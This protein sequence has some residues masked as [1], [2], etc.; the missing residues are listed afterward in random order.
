MKIL[1][2]L[3]IVTIFL[4]TNIS[5]VFSDITTSVPTN[6]I[7]SIATATSF[8]AIN[9]NT[10]ESAGQVQNITNEAINTEQVLEAVQEGAET[11]GQQNDDVALA[12]F[13]N[14]AETVTVNSEN[15]NKFAG[16]SDL[17]PNIDTL[18]Y[19]TGMMILKKKG[20]HYNADNPTDPDDKIFSTAFGAQRAR[21]LVYVDLKRN[22]LLGEIE[23]QVT[24]HIGTSIFTTAKGASNDL[25][26]IEF[27]LDGELTRTLVTSTGKIGVGA[28]DPFAWY[29]KGV[30]SKDGK[31]S[32]T[33]LVRADGD[34]AAFQ[35]NASS[36]ENEDERLDLQ[37]ALSHASGGNG[38]VHIGAR[39]VTPGEGSMGTSTAS[40]EASHAAHNADADVFAAGVVRYSATETPSATN[41]TD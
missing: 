7:Q 35:F 38:N 19:D 16:R 39:F 18:V 30:G 5:F 37:K 28:N 11:F 13:S 3:I 27:P 26:N 4:S 21:V 6:L 29:D 2:Y 40:F 8:T 41:I 10:A 23:S 32:I 15:E 24:L 20:G 33:S 31:H 22:V 14:E 36:S 17:E 25:T 1:K 12:A 34:P 9:E